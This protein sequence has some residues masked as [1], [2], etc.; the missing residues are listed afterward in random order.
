MAKPL[1]ELLSNE[2]V[3]VA[4]LELRSDYVV[5]VVRLELLFDEVVVARLGVADDEFT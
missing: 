5:A 2:V 3:V 1:L 4:R